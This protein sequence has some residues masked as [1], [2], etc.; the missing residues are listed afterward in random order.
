MVNCTTL[1]SVIAATLLVVLLLLLA[2][3]FYLQYSFGVCKSK[4]KMHGKTVIITGCTSGIG[5][6]TAKDIARRGARLIMA[7]RNLEAANKLKEELIKEFGNENIVTRKLDL[8]SFSSVREFAQQINREESRLDVL[9]HNAGTA[10]VFRKEVN[11]DGLEMTMAT[12][13]YGPFLLTHLLIDLLKLSKPS[14]IVVVAS[15]LYFL[16]RLNLNNP[17][18][19]TS[20]PA[21]LYYVSKYANIVFALELARRLEGSGVTANCLHPGLMNTGIWKKVPP[22]FSWGLSFLLKVFCKTVEQGAQTTIHLA[23]SSEVEGISGKYFSDCRTTTILIG[24]DTRLY[25]GIQTYHTVDVMYIV[26]ETNLP[27]GIK[28]PSMGKKFWELSETI[29]K[30]QPSDPKI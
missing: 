22:P 9:I 20:F 14:R 2:V 3:H 27:D 13:H 21:Y 23:V 29:V 5:R 7:C 24:I 26:Y 10:E 1:C 17:N 25:I 28:D 8:S 6:E 11:E 4:N 15:G 12:N 16:A 30:L 19:V 18:P